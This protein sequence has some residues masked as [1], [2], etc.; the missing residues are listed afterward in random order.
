MLILMPRKGP[1]MSLPER[2]ARAKAGAAA[3]YRGQAK[4][5]HQFRH[6][7]LLSARQPAANR[8]RK[9]IARPASAQE[10]MALER[11]DDLIARDCSSRRTC[12]PAPSKS[13]ANG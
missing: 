7:P 3:R 12:R 8:R 10:K 4:R 6:F 5:G 13:I 11:L 9:E 2:A 1:S